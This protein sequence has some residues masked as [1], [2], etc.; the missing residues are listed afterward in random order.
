MD[1]F[2]STTTGYATGGVAQEGSVDQRIATYRV[3][4][5][6]IKEDPF[7]GVG[8]DIYSVTRPFGQENDMYDQHNLVI[9]LWYKTGLL[10]LTG[11]FLV[12]FAIFR[13]GWR[14]ISASTSDGEWQLAVALVSSAVA[15]VVYAMSEPILFA[16]FAWI[17]AALVLALRAVQQEESVS[18]EP[19]A[20]ELDARRAVLAPARP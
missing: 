13:S 2:R 20:H 5:A 18:V 12:F 6:R 16:R 3:G 1:R 15:F 7:V 10:G 11:M 19:A 9:G 4:L 14:A 8:L 17:S